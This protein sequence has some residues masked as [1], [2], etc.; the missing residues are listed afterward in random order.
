MKD[1]TA[2]SVRAMMPKT[3]D[4]PEEEALIHNIKRRVSAAARADQDEITLKVTKYST[5]AIRAVIL[6]MKRNGFKMI[7]D[8]NSG[9]LKIMW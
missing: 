4:I 8:S 5:R 2:E 6:V 7:Y 1:F 9:H 3:P